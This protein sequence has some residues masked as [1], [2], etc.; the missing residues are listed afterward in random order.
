[1][2]LGGPRSGALTA[3][4]ETSQTCLLLGK[5]AAVSVATTGTAH[6]S[7]RAEGTWLAPSFNAHQEADRPVRGPEGVPTRA[8][9]KLCIAQ[10]VLGGAGDLSL[11]MLPESS[12]DPPLSMLATALKRM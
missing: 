5:A 12:Q 4:L 8:L 11:G 3:V 2:K 10:C 1:M 7:T 9:C 6:I